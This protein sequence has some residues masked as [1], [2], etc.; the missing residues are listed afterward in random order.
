MI[1]HG[2][3]CIQAV[4]AD[5]VIGDAGFDPEL[6]SRYLASRRGPFLE[7]NRPEVAE[8]ITLEFLANLQM[9]GLLAPGA[10]LFLDRLVA[11]DFGGHILVFA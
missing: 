10:V 4:L 1:A 11:G 3:E 2:R 5:L 9:G 6:K 8:K 7:V